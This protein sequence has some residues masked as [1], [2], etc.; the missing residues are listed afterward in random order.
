M[1]IPLV[2]ACNL[3]LGM[4]DPGTTT[5]PGSLDGAKPRKGTLTPEAWQEADEAISSVKG[6]VTQI[7]PRALIDLEVEH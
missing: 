7:S 2:I 4:C 6:S 1:A 5:A 3:R